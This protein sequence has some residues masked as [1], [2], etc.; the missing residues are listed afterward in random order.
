MNQLLLRACLLLLLSLPMLQ[1]QAQAPAYPS[2]P[3]RIVIAFPPGGS[4]DLLARLL[5][6]K[7]TTAM[8]QPVL[9]ENRPGGNFVIAAEAVAKSPPDGYTLF[10]AVDSTMSVNTLLYSKLSYDPEKDFTPISLVALQSLFMV[11]GPKA[12]AR[13]L[14]GLIAYARANPG[15]L[16]YG[17]SAILQQLTGEKIKLDAKVDMLH[18]PFKGSPPM[19]QA[20]LNGEI[21]FAITVTTPYSTY[22]KDGRLFGLVTSGAK[23]EAALPATPVMRE[24]GF[25]DLEFSNW[26]GLFAPAGTPEAIIEKL[27]AEVKKAMGDPALAA[28]LAPTGIVPSTG[29]PEQ[30]RALRKSDVERWGKVIKASGIKLD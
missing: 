9:V 11:A 14:P 19:L 7:L 4:T 21:D 10:L 1:A 8:Q 13:D 28:R 3:V 15:K 2:K 6:E 20:L 22:V 16:T 5:A 25:P 27:N 12:P 18:V 17:S 30:L 23:R 26:T 24:V 29:T